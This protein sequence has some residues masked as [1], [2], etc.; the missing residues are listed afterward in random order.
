MLSAIITFEHEDGADQAV[1]HMDQG[2]IDGAHVAVTLRERPDLLAAPPAPRRR[3]WGDR[4]YDGGGG[5]HSRYGWSGRMPPR[6]H[7]W[8]SRGRRADTHDTLMPS[9]RERS[10]SRERAQ[11]YSPL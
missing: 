5:K 9:S 2:Q 10:A 11:S 6:E 3:V 1:S 8:A 7:G 4:F